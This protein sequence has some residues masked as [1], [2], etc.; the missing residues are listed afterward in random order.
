MKIYD[1][2]YGEF[3]LSN[4]SAT[5]ANT[6]E[7]RRL[8]QVRLL[9][10]MTPSLATLGELRR[11]AH[12]LGVLNLF[13]EWR[14]IHKAMIPCTELDAL[15]VA[16][17]L[18]DVATPPFGHLFE[19]LLKEELGWDHESAAS[20]TLLQQHVPENVGHQIFVG[21]TPK[22][23][24]L[25][26]KLKLDL[27]IVLAILRKQHP[28]HTLIFGTIDFDNID[29][30]WRMAWALGCRPDPSVA[31]ELARQLSVSP[32]GSLVLSSTSKPLVTQ[33]AAIRRSDYEVLV[34]DHATVASQ[35]I[36]TKA[37]RIGMQA[38]LIGPEDWT[39]TDEQ[40]LERLLSNKATKKLI[41][42]DYLGALPKPLLTIQ[43][44]WKSAGK[45]SNTRAEIEIAVSEIARQLIG[46]KCV[47]YVL[48]EKGS[49]SKELKWLNEGGELQTQGS[50]SKSVIIYI[51]MGSADT[52]PAR[53][54]I[55][56]LNHLCNY[57]ETEPKDIIRTFVK[58]NNVS[59]QST[60]SF[61]F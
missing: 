53:D 58:G 40:L 43:F 32:S 18:H 56:L 2:L 14:K 48:K 7:V 27:D 33:W 49:F 61:D 60:L 46:D 12:T 52:V 13:G 19:Y 37:L 25:V 59:Q 39:L 55:N 36:L 4:I 8:S 29:N 54:T 35:A 11:Y 28:L 24:K 30:V 38:G 17:I 34:F 3:S 31:V 26:R 42:D 1:P 57:F 5:L 9:N 50:L 6:P 47:V 20:E 44:P 16:I 23:Q 22:V 15:E 41:S 21:R 10:S 51:F 45:L